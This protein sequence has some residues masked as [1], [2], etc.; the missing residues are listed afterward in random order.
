[1][2][3][4]SDTKYR[5]HKPD[6]SF[7]DTPYEHSKEQVESRAAGVDVQPAI[8][9]GN[10]VVNIA[11]LILLKVLI[12]SRTTSKNRQKLSSVVSKMAISSVKV[13]TRLIFGNTGM[14]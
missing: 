2:L 14:R 10:I 9:C 3:T 13:L 5:F 8:E 6:I 11:N 12:I 1:M 4:S 7:T